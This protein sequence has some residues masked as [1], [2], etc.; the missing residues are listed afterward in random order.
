MIAGL[1]IIRTRS[2][3]DEDG[4]IRS[5]FIIRKD[6]MTDHSGGSIMGTNLYAVDPEGVAMIR[7]SA[8][9]AADGRGP[10][11]TTRVMV[12]SYQG[13]PFPFLPI[14]PPTYRT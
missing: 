6:D 9:T 5:L 14:Y 12:P 10:F 1:K 8:S 11:R 2:R 3:L 7:P 13:P 4:W